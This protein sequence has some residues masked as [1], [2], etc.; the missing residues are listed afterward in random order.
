MGWIDAG[1]RR[2]RCELEQMLRHGI[3]AL[4]IIFLSAANTTVSLQ[5]QPG[6]LASIQARAEQGDAESQYLLGA[7]YAAGTVVEQDFAEA[8]VWFRLSAEQGF[9]QSYLPLAQAYRD[10]QGVTQD[11]LSAHVWFNIAASRLAGDARGAAI[12]VRDEIETR[13]TSTQIAESQQVARR[14]LPGSDPI[15]ELNAASANEAEP[16]RPATSDDFPLGVTR[17]LLL[18]TDYAQLRQRLGEPFS[19]SGL[20]QGGPAQAVYKFERGL[21]TIYFDEGRVNLIY[22]L[23]WFSR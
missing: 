6:V 18:G 13:M 17:E 16:S 4:L 10:G 3:V 15:S 19:T 12:E 9:P 11:F 1:G 5:A 14:W 2:T 8:G 22:P 21:L 23:D 20:S 7:M